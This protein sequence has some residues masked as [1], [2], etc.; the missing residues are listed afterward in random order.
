MLSIVPVEAVRD[1][2]EGFGAGIRRIASRLIRE[3][4]SGPGGSGF[5][6]PAIDM[7]QAYLEKRGAEREPVLGGLV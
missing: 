7:R 6:E 2:I 4:N 1:P 3:I 5:E